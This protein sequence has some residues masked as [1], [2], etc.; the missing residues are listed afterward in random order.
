MA[1]RTSPSDSGDEPELTADVADFEKQ[2]RQ[3]VRVG[4]DLRARSVVSNDELERL[5]TDR[6]VW[7]E[8][9]STLLRRSFST[10]KVGNEYS[11][12]EGPLVMGPENLPSRVSTERKHIGRKLDRLNAILTQL[13]LYVPKDA[14]VR[15]APSETAVGDSIF[16]VHG[17]DEAWKQAVA[18]FVEKLVAGAPVV[19]LHEQPNDGSKTIIEKLEAYAGRAGFAIILLTGDDEGRIKG[20]A[21]WSLR[22]RQN[23]VLELGMFMGRLGRPRVAVL[24]QTGVELPSDISGVLYTELDAGGGWKVALAREIQGAGFAVD[25]AQLLR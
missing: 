20:D 12:W 10:P 1:R 9:N 17:R 24:Y 14:T 22:A 4:E 19:I 13:P 11:G 3:Q 16:I 25:T 6:Y 15:S 5:R 8:F 18:R 2:L 23:V 7:D 21:E